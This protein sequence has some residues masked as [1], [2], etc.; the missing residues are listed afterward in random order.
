MKRLIRSFSLIIG[1]IFL[2]GCA[3]MTPQ[4]IDSAD[5]P[6]G[7][8]EGYEVV[9]SDFRLSNPN[10][11]KKP[12]DCPGQAVAISQFPEAK[13]AEVRNKDPERGCFIVSST[14]GQGY[15][16]QEYSNDEYGR[17][18][19]RMDSI[20]A[21]GTAAQNAVLAYGQ[22]LSKRM[23]EDGLRFLNTYQLSALLGSKAEIAYGA[24]VLDTVISSE[25][26][27]SASDVLAYTRFGFY[28]DCVT[29]AFDAA[30]KAEMGS[31][32]YRIIKDKPACRVPTKEKYY[33]PDYVNARSSES[34]A[35]FVYPYKVA[36]K[37]GAISFS[38]VEPSFGMK[39]FSKEN[40]SLPEDLNIHKGFA[41]INHSLSKVLSVISISESSVTLGL[42]TS[43][44]GVI[45]QRT[46]VLDNSESD[47]E[48]DGLY[49]S[50]EAIK[51][52]RVSLRLSGEFSG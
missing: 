1:I 51:G 6:D 3:S 45:E 4:P 50:L 27:F 52:A 13:C 19:A 24:E 29:P 48:I 31:W 8:W 14:F 25:G 20:V 47:A 33:M 40:L 38:V 5:I 2:S 10:S 34:K 39:A 11:A 15:C 44:N 9:T 12:G 28:T 26:D 32:Y 36:E 16:P 22:N 21:A 35:S 43:K 49:V 7:L 46:V 37:K 41:S 17:A 30:Y 18:T 23:Q 42:M